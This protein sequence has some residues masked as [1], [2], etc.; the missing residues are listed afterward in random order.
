MT[1]LMLYVVLYS[2]ETLAIHYDTNGDCYS[3]RKDVR[4]IVNASR[5]GLH[6]IL[7][8]T[9]AYWLPSIKTII[10]DPLLVNY[11]GL[12]SCNGLFKDFINLKRIIGLEYLNTS[13]VTDMHKMFYG[14]SSLTTLDVRN[15]DTSNV[16]D[17][18]SDARR[19]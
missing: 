10:I 17:M 12:T 18:S 6:A 13:N 5:N 7:T 8:G 11:N 19:R 4:V 14:C 9:M 2:E 1:T 15:F 3:G 16:T